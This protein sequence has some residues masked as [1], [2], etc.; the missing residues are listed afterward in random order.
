M[1]RADLQAALLEAFGRDDLRLGSACAGFEQDG[2]RVTATFGE[3]TRA[4]AD[5]LIGADG[6]HSV[7]RTQLHGSHPPRYA[8]CT[9]WRAAVPFTASYS[10]DAF[11]RTRM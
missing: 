5:L 7:V 11:A 3:G 9:A 10:D 1:H 2:D 4:G 8:G 6:L